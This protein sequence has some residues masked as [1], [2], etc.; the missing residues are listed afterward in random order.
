MPSFDVMILGAGGVGCV[1]GGHLSAKGHSVQLV[2]RST[3]TA[4]AIGAG[5]LRLELNDGVQVTHP[6]A[7]TPDK[8]GHTRI[9]MCFTKTH[10]TEHAVRAV[11]PRM[12][13]ETIYVS[14][15]N[16]LGNGA[17]LHQI[18]GCDVLHG[19]T[20]IPATVLG[21]AHVRS[22]GSHKSWL[23]PLD[24]DNV[25]QSDSARWL[26]ESLGSAGLETEYHADVLPR[27][28]QKACFNVAMNGLS[29][30]AD[31]APGLIGDIALL[32]V[33]AHCLADEALAVATAL[34]VKTDPG[35]VHDMIDFAC[36]E[37]RYHQPSMLQDIRAQRQTE[38]DSLNGYIV[39]Q[40]ER[41]GIDTPRNRLVHALVLA[42]QAA[43]AFWKSQP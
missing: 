18:T 43:P 33:E 14:M 31:A 41:L 39:G 1:V 24:S 28:W 2:N 6:D 5:G 40:A 42:R 19:V 12:T 37:H 25:R 35:Q 17:L 26:T 32:K 11:L 20:L 30:L 7:V 4:K 21:P 13:P 3:D 34:G 29:A 38:I 22:L 27:I 9:V 23:G 16:G 36:A 10:Q 8:A 15:Q